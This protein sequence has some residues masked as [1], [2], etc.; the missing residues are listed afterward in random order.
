MKLSIR[1]A[2]FEDPADGA[3]ILHVLD[4]YAADP[5]GG[6][7]PLSNEV[8][9]RLLPALRD[10]GKA[11]AVLAFDAAAP[12]GL[13]IGFLGLSTFQAR[14]LLN[15]HDLAVVPSHRGRGIGRAL[16]MAVEAKALQHRCCKLT[17]EVQD[18]NSRARELYE[19][20]GFTDYV[21]DVPVATRFL[22]KALPI[23]DS[24]LGS[25]GLDAGT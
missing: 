11:L 2:A 12:V 18:D 4:S 24:A 13:A 23:A 1:E 16:L 22:C 8:R 6:G 21:L 15:I 25:G 9:Q 20:F 10:H 19:R 5:L 3:A 17:L 14:P 7:Q